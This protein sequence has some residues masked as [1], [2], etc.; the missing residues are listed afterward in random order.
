MDDIDD[1]LK[2]WQGDSSDDGETSRT[3]TGF[4]PLEALVDDQ[5]T[6]EG[7]SLTHFSSPKKSEQNEASNT[8]FDDLLDSTTN[9][10][11]G[12]SDGADSEVWGEL[13]GVREA[14]TERPLEETDWGDGNASEP[15]E[16]VS[17]AESE[18]W[19]EDSSAEAQLDDSKTIMADPAEAWASQTSPPEDV[20]ESQEWPST[21]Q[22]EQLSQ[23]QDVVDELLTTPTVIDEDQNNADEVKQSADSAQIDSSNADAEDLN[24]PAST[25]WADAPETK[26]SENPELSSL[27]SDDADPWDAQPSEDEDSWGAV[28]TDEDTWAE[29]TA[30]TASSAK[31][32]E[33]DSKTAQTPAEDNWG[34]DEE[35]STTSDEDSWGGTEEKATTS[36]E[37][38]WGGTEE[39]ATTPDEDSW[40]GAEEK[41]TTPDEDSWGGTEEKATTP[42]EDSWGA[43]ASEDSPKTME[44]S[45]GATDTT[46]QTQ[47]AEENWANETSSA[48]SPEDNQAWGDLSTQ[49]NVEATQLDEVLEALN[50]DPEVANAEDEFVQRKAVE[51]GPSLADKA[52]ALPGI[53]LTFLIALVGKPLSYL[54][55]PLRPILVKKTG[56]TWYDWAGG[57]IMVQLFF[58]VAQC[59]FILL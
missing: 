17:S 8:D 21:A 12:P 25:D 9:S 2:E 35:K 40:G 56:L 41:A 42:D 47:P 29:K 43:A 24:D 23:G 26:I 11:T 54:E 31:K 44:D 45:W 59:Y 3:E 36:D 19:L 33:R 39:K 49:S 51:K 15:I 52:R 22:D 32:V 46:A 16:Q 27:A 1:I 10:A 6:E 58:V 55:P 30:P 38:S 13:S 34:A 14:T 28:A 48:A 5:W 53:F 18:S 7:T 4:D 37:D 20:E 57:L 50:N